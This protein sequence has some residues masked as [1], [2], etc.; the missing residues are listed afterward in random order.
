MKWLQRQ[1]MLVLPEIF[2]DILMPL[3]DV[4]AHVHWHAAEL[5][6][7]AILRGTGALMAAHDPRF[8]ALEVCQSAITWRHFG[9]KGT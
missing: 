6:N 5:V 9:R 7:H 2:D 1:L 8:R 4:G 3:P